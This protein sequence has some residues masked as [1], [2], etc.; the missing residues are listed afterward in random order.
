MRCTNLDIYLRFLKIRTEYRVYASHPCIC[1]EIQQLREQQN[2]VFNIL[3]VHS[4]RAGST[5]PDTNQGVNFHSIK[6]IQ[7]IVKGIKSKSDSPILLAASIADVQL[8]TVTKA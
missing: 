4:L 2:F 5:E 6:R 8:R 3:V 7:L 1:Q